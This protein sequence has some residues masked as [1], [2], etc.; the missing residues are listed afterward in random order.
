METDRLIIRRC[1]KGDGEALF[2]LLESNDNR[3]FLLDHVDDASTVKTQEDAEIRIRQ[4]SASWVARERFVLGIWLKSS[5]LY[6]GQLW[7][8][9]K[10]WEVPSFE[11][12]YFL[13]RTH[14]DQGKATEAA[15]RAIDF[16]FD[17]LN[18]HKIIILTRDD[19]ERSYRLAE[20]CGFESEGHLLDHDVIDGRRIGLLCYRL[21]RSEH[22]DEGRDGRT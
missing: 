4:L 13:D 11:L 20:R 18:A 14:Q 5:N 15:K 21:L 8:E 10:K 9:P 3:E 19:N 7:I 1:E 2:T 12:G 22:Y 16:L 6:I 17:D